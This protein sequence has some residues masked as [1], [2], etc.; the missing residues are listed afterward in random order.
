[1]Q[2]APHDAALVARSSAIT[3]RWSVPLLPV[4]LLI[5]APPSALRAPGLPTF[6][7]Y[8]TIPASRRLSVCMT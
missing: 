2:V 5:L 4:A 8:G 7:P 3:S 6:R 1:M